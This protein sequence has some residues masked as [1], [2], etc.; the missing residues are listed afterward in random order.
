MPTTGSTSPAANPAN[1]RRRTF[2]C[3]GYEVEVKANDLTAWRSSRTYAETVAY[4]K[5]LIEA[6]SGAILG[7]HLVGHGAEESIHIFAL[8]I[9]N[10]LTAADLGELV[11]AYPTFISDIKNMMQ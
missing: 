6:G 5:I 4:S 3:G 11:P 10:G 2:G 1:Y 7:A 8:A 9:K